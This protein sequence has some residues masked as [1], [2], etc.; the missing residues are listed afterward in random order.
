VTLALYDLPTR[1][2]DIRFRRR[3]EFAGRHPGFHPENLAAGLMALPGSTEE[4][5]RL[6][7]LCNDNR[8]PVV[9]QG[10]RTGLSGATA[11]GPEELILDTSGLNR[12]VSI[13]PTGATAIVESGVRLATL[14]STANDHGLSSG[15]DLAARDSATIGGMTA[16]NAGGISAFRHGV[17]A[18][19]V[20]GIEAVLADGGI[21]DGLKRVTKANEGLDITRLL[22]GSEG[23]LGVITKVSLALVPVDP[24]AATAL[25]LFPDTARAVE[26]VAALRNSREVELLAAEAM[27]PDYFHSVSE[28]L[29]IPRPVPVEPDATTLPVLIEAAAESAERR[30]RFEQAMMTLLEQD[31]L[32]DVVIARNERER[33]GFWRIRE[34]SFTVDDQFPHGLWYDVSVPL[35]TL[36]GYIEGLH[37]AIDEISADLRVFLIAH[38]GDGNIHAT[39]TTGEPLTQWKNRIDQA[40]YQGLTAAGGSFSAEHGIGIDKRAILADE[41]SAAHRDLMQRVKTAFDPNGILNPGKVL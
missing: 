41:L 13:D 19:R 10:G 1:L 33:A 22:A 31:L 32:T 4:V 12:V 9:T 39:I 30:E 8:I 26:G 6:L 37:Q 16:T 35:D 20:L 14:E 17:M 40:V 23:I 18:N 34:D 25:C 29:A 11:T 24:P 3:E 15:I 7:A 21:I 28:A 2:P 27:W 5:S 36:P 38:L